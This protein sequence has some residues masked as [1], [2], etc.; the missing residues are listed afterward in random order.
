MTSICLIAQTENSDIICKNMHCNA[1]FSSNTQRSHPL[2]QNY[3]LKYYK[4]DWFIDP[5][6]YAIQGSATIHFQTLVNDF[7][8]IHFEL[9][10]LLHIDSIMFHG[11]NIKD[12]SQPEDFLLSINLPTTISISTLDSIKIIYS[13]VPPS[14]G[15]GSFIQSKHSEVP[16]IWTLSEP[17][18]ARDWWPCK[19]GLD[20]KIDSIDVF[21]THASEYKAASNGSLISET[22]N[23]NLMTAHW[24]HKYAI[25]PYLVA[26]AVTNYDVFTNP[27]LLND[28]TN[29]P[30]LNYVYPE[31]KDV[32]V[33]GTNDLVKVLQFYDSLFVTYPFSKEKY[34]HAEFGWGGG[35][36][37]QTMSFVVNYDWGLLSHELAHQWFGDLVTCGSWKDIWLNEGFATYLEGLTRERFPN[38]GY[39]WMD[40]KRAKI[41]SITSA[42]GGSVSVK[43]TT[44]VGGIFSGRLSYNKGS[45]LLNMLRWK[46][47]NDNFFN[48]VRAYLK[49]RGYNNAITKDF[50]HYLEQASGQDLNTFFNDWFKGEGYPSYTL[51]WH[52]ENNGM[53]NIKVDQTTSHSSVAFFEM[54]LP[55]LLKGDRDSIIRVENTFSGQ[56]FSLPIGYKI[57][58]IEFDPDLWLISKDNT[59]IDDLPSST[60]DLENAVVIFPNP[61][62]NILT[63]KTSSSDKILI[64][65]A[66]GKIM[67]TNCATKEDVSSYQ[68]GI[69]FCRIQ[70]AKGRVKTVKF[71]KQ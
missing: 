43:D 16:V 41:N 66:I 17:F 49:G 59:I 20:D 69:Y 51:H 37:H 4:F 9:S 67:K 70:D 54:P 27:V 8:V 3:D 53:L 23:G 2:T 55:I 58:S 42:P 39:A 34:G 25:M 26:I 68:S 62:T 24:K 40:W 65:N 29:M 12:F 71:V 10:K 64:I 33:K 30:M 31:H 1:H 57:S 48:G 44:S 28:G 38:S 15:L 7:N 50:Q 22:I 13:G 32:A 45:Y 63:I 47:G 52:Q 18:G 6:V 14:G 56:T 46:L 21:I 60:N 35:M 19:N 5:A 61:V 36:E 11:A